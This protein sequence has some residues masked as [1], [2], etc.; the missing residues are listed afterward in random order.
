MTSP[1]NIPTAESASSVSQVAH[2][3]D[4]AL[5]ELGDGWVEGEVRSITRHRSGHVYL[6]L[7]DEDSNLD[8][9]IW[10]GRIWRCEPLPAQ[11]NLVQAHYDRIDFHAPRGSTKLIIDFIKPTG[12]GELLRRR[13]EALRRLQ[14]DGLCDADRRK[15]LPAFPRTV[16]VI[17]AQ[18]SDAKADVVRAV[19]E[20][21]PA[22]NIA[23][24]PAA[25]QGVEAVGSVIDALGRLQAV[26]GVDVIIVARG[27]G[28]VADL[29]AFDDERLCRAIF[30][31]S[32]PVI[33]SIGHTKDR[34]NCDHVA[35]AYATVPAKAAEHAISRSAADVLAE[36]D[37][38]A[39]ALAGV[40]SVVL[41]LRDDVVAM[42]QQVRVRQRLAEHAADVLAADELLSSRADAMYRRRE[43]GVV[44]TARRLDGVLRRA[45]RPRLLD[46]LRME[47]QAAAGNYIRAQR[48]NL[49][50]FLATLD[51]S[52][53]RIQRPAALDVLLTH[54]NHA[55]AGAQKKRRD[56]EAALDRRGG[57]ALREVRRRLAAE[58]R[59]V[60]G[61]AEPLVPDARRAIAGAQERVANLS[62]LRDAK[63]FRRHGWVLACDEHGQAVRTTAA[64]QVG[65][66]LQL[67]FADGEAQTIVNRITPEGE[68]K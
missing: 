12:E 17:A 42:W 20:R 3:I 43:I 46:A 7:A 36:L 21:F 23:F 45:P 60:S 28:S 38:H 47:L 44:E 29:V 32:V 40:S 62:A 53:R 18:G 59:Q 57:E 27:G 30:A 51:A 61:Q 13:A 11:G 58:H 10:K 5:R 64:L 66:E 9:C 15:P 37:R 2:R 50:E 6:T 56:F 26:H 25:V 35:A 55:T 33:T 14:A 34:P 19:R 54:L 31:C 22:Q 16:G 4:G 67:R 8:A 52:A 1:L 49:D 41:R 39:V 48:D 24:C 65:A 68:G 63:D